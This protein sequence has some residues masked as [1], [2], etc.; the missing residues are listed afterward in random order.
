MTWQ[1]IRGDCVEAMAGLA[2]GSVDAVVTD[3]PYGL[4]SEPDTAEV[5]RHWL[6]GDD[7]K[8]RGGGFMGK[9]WDSFVPGPAVWRECFRV[10]KPGGHLLCFA[11][12]RTV[13]LMG[14]AIRLA[15]FER[16]DLIAF[17][18]GS[19]FPKSLDVSKA[20]D[21]RPGVASHREFAAHLVER[22]EAA[23]LAR[24]DVSEKVVGT[25]SGA[26]WNWEHHQF[27]EAKWWP[28]LR[29]LLGL[30]DERWGLVI[31]EAER[32][33]LARVAGGH[34]W[35]KDG[36]SGH[37]EE[38][39]I[40]APAT[41]EAER[42]QGWGTA[43]KPAHEPVVVARKP[44][45]GTVAGN[46]L[47]YGTGALAID[48]CRV[49]HA[50][51]EDLAESQAKN[52][53]RDDL[54]SSDVYGA[55]R[56]QQSVNAAGRWPANVV[57]S[58]ECPGDEHDG[59]LCPVR[60]LDEQTGERPGAVS[61]GQRGSADDV[62]GYDGG[63]GAREQRPGYGDSGGASRF[64][65]TVPADKICV[66]C[67][68]PL[69]ESAGSYTP[70]SDPVPATAPDDAPA[71]QSPEPEGSSR[72]SDTSAPIAAESSS[73]TPPTSMATGPTAPP[74]AATP[75]ADWIVQHARSAASLC[76]SCATATAHE[77]AERLR[78][79]IEE[80]LAGPGST[81]V[82]SVRILS[83][84]LALIAEGS[85]STGTIP[86]TATL[87]AL[88]G[89]AAAVTT[90][91]TPASVTASEPDRLRLR[92]CPKSSRAERNA[93]LEGFEETWRGTL[94]GGTHERVDDRA[95]KNRTGTVARNVHPTVKPVELMRWLVRLVTPPGGTVLD[96]FAGSGTTGIAAV[97][98][99]FSFTGIEREAEYA[100]IAEARIRWWEKHR[101]DGLAAEVL[102]AGNARDEV[103]ATGQGSLLDLLEDDAA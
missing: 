78:N 86:T 92:Y 76:D 63:W 30:D 25:R 56:P 70:P 53:G 1:I 40:T 31:A 38:F 33:K 64:F 34:G 48:A 26:C 89:S 18:F 49:G 3:P 61:N 83:Q 95:G 62:A 85:R 81:S 37:G 91:R 72:N 20:I 47:Q 9:T 88:C 24:A 27:P 66:L 90:G 8:H 23:G 100:D 101:G 98:E 12:T 71:P 14:V 93:G 13:D 22:R 44:L 43:L 103:A 75:L 50:S 82:P 11:G 55:G 6:A 94:S 65:L 21:K 5:L 28:A 67:S 45:A 87:S 84:S 35:A 54:V 51:P 2:D 59:E 7:Y 73:T 17:M 96:P 41:P 102:A 99:G 46:V 68:L 80:S 4:G 57:L 15:G 10:L 32:E 16:R 52:P 60:L 69:V 97:L 19:G 58:C 74:T 79:P 29:D 42:W 77:V 39:D 36:L